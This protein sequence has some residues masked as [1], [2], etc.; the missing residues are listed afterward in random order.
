[1]NT[2]TRSAVRVSVS[3]CRRYLHWR[4]QE[5]A[6]K[7]VT[8]QRN[9]AEEVAAWLSDSNLY[10]PDF[11]M[12]KLERLTLSGN[13]RTN[14]RTRTVEVSSSNRLRVTAAFKTLPKTCGDG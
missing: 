14:K 5:E 12:V 7:P 6:V 8:Q 10:V 1:M 11:I 4:K 3:R 13:R 9:S 2:M